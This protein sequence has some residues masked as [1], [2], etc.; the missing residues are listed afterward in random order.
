MSNYN[1]L[2]RY[3]DYISSIGISNTVPFDFTDKSNN[4]D[5]HIANMLIRTSS[6][7]CWKNLP[8]TI[9]Q[10]DLELMLQ[11]NGNVFITEVDGNLYA[12]NG[13]TGGNP[14]VY[15]KP[16]LYTVANPVLKLSK[17]FKIGEDGVLIYNDILLI[18]VL[19]FF[20]KY[21]TN[22]SEIELSL[23]IANINSRILKLISAPD[24]RSKANADMFLKDIQD[25]K[26]AA[27]A[28]NTFLNGIN[29][30]SYS[31][32]GRSAIIDLIELYQYTKASWYNEIGLNSNFNMKRESLNSAES[33]L[34]ND[35]LMPYV[36]C[37]L[38]CR[39]D[40]IDAVNKMYGTNI[41]VDLDSSWKDNATEIEL[42][43]EQI[44]SEVEQNESEV[45]YEEN[46]DRSDT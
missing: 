42:E 32:S 34:N 11:C 8:D 39:Q 18:G 38:K 33:G 46:T 3:K 28:D 14:D 21:A 31:D 12:F 27:I 22:L 16:T 41:T 13:S 44:E 7:F 5:I 15:L 6:M 20:T 43:L 4:I 24:D 35:M 26:L 19:P 29:T 2:R 30:L 1:V 23:S 17:Q 25:G 36:H 45:E 10:R 40:G 9:L 37:M